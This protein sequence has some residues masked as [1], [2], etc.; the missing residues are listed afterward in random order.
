MPHFLSRNYTQMDPKA[1]QLA[2]D[3]SV[4]PEHVGSTHLRLM[5][6]EG[7]EYGCR[8]EIAEFII[9]AYWEM[10]LQVENDGANGGGEEGPGNEFLQQISNSL[11]YHVNRG[12]HEEAA[13]VAIYSLEG[14]CENAVPSGTK[15]VQFN[16]V[17]S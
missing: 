2:V 4:L 9:T 16:K 7:K 5:L 17:T 3:L 8:P 11:L 1:K 14:E 12:Y 15:R 10:L 13:V 6:T